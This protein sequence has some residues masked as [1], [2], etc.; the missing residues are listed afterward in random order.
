LSFNHD[1][2]LD[3]YLAVSVSTNFSRFTAEL[4]AC[5]SMWL[6][7]LAEALASIVIDLQTTL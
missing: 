2:P 4:I 6:L 1:E 7:P 5:I 3:E